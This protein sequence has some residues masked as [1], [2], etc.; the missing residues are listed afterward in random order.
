MSNHKDVALA[1]L[2]K[3][4]NRA[5]TEVDRLRKLFKETES[6]DVAEKLAEA[7]SKLTDANTRLANHRATM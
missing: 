4:Q 7:E 2:R 5:Q 3:K 1:G 6:A